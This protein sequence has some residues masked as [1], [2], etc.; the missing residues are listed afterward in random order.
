MLSRFQGMS[1]CM[2][3]K[4][5]E[6]I[7]AYLQFN[8][9][10]SKITLT[11][12]DKW[13]MLSISIPTQNGVWEIVVFHGWYNTWPNGK[14]TI[15]QN[16]LRRFGTKIYADYPQYNGYID[17]LSINVKN[18]QGAL[19][20]INTLT[21]IILA[22]KHPPTDPKF[23]QLF[24]KKEIVDDNKCKSMQKYI[25]FFELPDETYPMKPIR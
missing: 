4:S 23:W 24:S 5:M 8:D 16:P 7:A 10:Y 3:R 14:P 11:P 12:K 2:F 6:Q 13:V 19:T 22:F 1:P 25:H 18:A 17:H 21:E 20:A 9:T 15:G